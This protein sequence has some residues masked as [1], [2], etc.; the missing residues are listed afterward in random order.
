MFNLFDGLRNLI[1]NLGTG[2]DK[3]EASEY[4]FTPMTRQQILAAYRSAWLPK[5]IVQIPAQDATRA[6]RQWSADDDQVKAL[7]DAEKA[8]KLQ[9]KVERAIRMARLFGGS[10]IYMGLKDR[11]PAA[12]VEIESLT[13]DCIEYLTVLS[14]DWVSASELDMDPGSEYFGGPKFYNLSLPSGTA[15]NNVHPSRLAIFHAE[16]QPEWELG[17]GLVWGDPVIQSVYNSIRNHDSTTAS[18]ASL[19]FEAKIDILKIPVL[20]KNADDPRYAKKMTER[21]S[22]A[23]LSKSINGMLVMDA[24]EEF[25]QRQYSFAALADIIDRFSQEVS[26]AADIPMTR[27]FGRSPAGMNSTGESDMRNYYDN[28]SSIQ[29]NRIRPAMSVLDDVL[30]VHALGDKPEDI[31][32]E[33]RSLWQTSQKEDAEVANS[34][35]GAL[36]KLAKMRALPD[37][38]M[39]AI[40]VSS[41][42]ELKSFPGVKSAIDEFG[43][44]VEDP[45]KSNELINAAMEAEAARMAQENG[46]GATGQAPGTKPAA[47][48]RATKAGQAAQRLAK[49]AAPRSLYIRRDVVNSRD[50]HRWATS[51]GIKDLVPAEELHVTVCYSKTPV[52]WFKVGESWEDKIDL[53]GGPRIV[54]AFPGGPIVL[55]IG[56]SSL[57][58]RHREIMEAGGSHDFPEYQPHITL[59]KNSDQ[60]LKDVTPY[61][62]RILLGP[63]IFE[64][65]KND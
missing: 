38:T 33:W 21:T 62:G 46:Q 34:V 60:D 32:Y 57:K 24:K 39:Q 13:Q 16:D 55:L 53:V 17:T 12:P 59:S 20:M 40:V 9:L 52:D 48:G 50:L 14:C 44:E 2:R 54:E 23:A 1:A 37:E 56:A 8:L 29:N 28:I 3:A 6:W 42:Q 5:K 65:V 11:N 25:E 31:D 64:E 43:L 63:E 30:V 45:F 10:A 51:Q 61:Q 22:I 4:V 35:V 58:W 47:G 49:D 7:E 36:D 15:V 18:V 27:L 26:G 19:V 41:V